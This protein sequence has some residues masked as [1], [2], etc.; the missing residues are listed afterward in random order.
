[1]AKRQGSYELIRQVRP[2]NYKVRHPD[3]KKENW[4]YHVNL[5]KLWTARKGLLIAT[6]PYEPELGSQ[7]GMSVADSKIQ[8]GEHLT[9][10]QRR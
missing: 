1:M 9:S 4:I 7:I 3:W 8:L 10:G 6:C 5:L 2:V